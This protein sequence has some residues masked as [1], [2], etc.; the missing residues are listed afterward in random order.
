MNRVV[1]CATGEKLR[2][3][4][5]HVHSDGRWEWLVDDASI[6]HVGLDVKLKELGTLDN[7]VVRVIHVEGEE[8][9]IRC[10][11]KEAQTDREKGRHRHQ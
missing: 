9:K 7:V 6:V 10:Y 2:A 8:G 4:D 1:V 5:I 3:D 11:G